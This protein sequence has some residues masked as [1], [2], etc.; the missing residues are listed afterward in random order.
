M[1][2]KNADLRCRVNDNLEVEFTA[3]G[4]TSYAG[5]ELLMRYLRKIKWNQQL[6]R[7]LGAVVSGGDFGVERLVRVLLGLLVVGGRRLHHLNFL[8][9]D[10]LLQRFCGLRD[11]PTDRSVSTF[12][13][14]FTD[15]GLKALQALNA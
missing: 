12:L 6:R 11:L 4:L 7:R 14:R 13:R 1:R 15:K 2:R 3:E 8:K 10:V 5:L 9:G